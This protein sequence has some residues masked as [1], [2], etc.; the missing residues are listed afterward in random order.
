MLSRK[1]L[2]RS[3]WHS[4]DDYSFPKVVI[5]QSRWLVMR[6]GRNLVGTPLLLLA[7]RCRRMV[8][9]HRHRRGQLSAG[10]APEAGRKNFRTLS[11]LIDGLPRLD[12]VPH[13]SEKPPSLLPA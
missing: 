5:D 10:S 4:P 2:A 11:P 12:P 3:D 8:R 6:L 13:P 7:H 1:A 9:S